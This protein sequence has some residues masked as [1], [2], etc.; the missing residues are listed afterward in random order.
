[1]VAFNLA[2]T[3]AFISVFYWFG[4]DHSLLA[5]GRW[6]ALFASALLVPMYWSGKVEAELARLPPPVSPG[7]RRASLYPIL[8][9]IMTLIA[10]MAFLAPG[11]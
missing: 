5:L 10:A 6:V 3:L 2:G 4:G 11:H 7:L 1:M 8:A 9:G